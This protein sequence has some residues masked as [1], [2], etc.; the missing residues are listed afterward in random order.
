MGRLLSGCVFTV[1][2]MACSLMSSCSCE[3]FEVMGDDASTKA[4]NSIGEVKQACQ[5]DSGAPPETDG[6]IPSGSCIYFVDAD[7][8]NPSTGLSWDTAFLLV[9]DALEAAG[10]VASAGYQCEVW[11]AEGTYHVWQGQRYHTTELVPYV[12]LYGGFDGTEAER[13]QRDWNAHATILEGRN[14]QNTDDGVLHVVTG[15]DNAVIDGF[16]ITG[17]MA[18]TYDGW[19][20]PGGGVYNNSAS[21]VIRNCVINNNIAN[22]SGGGIYNVF[23]NPH[24]EN[25]VI[26]NNHS[27][28]RGGG[29]YNYVSNP[30][31]IN[32]VF[33]GNSVTSK[34]GAIANFGG[35][36]PTITNITVYNNT[37]GEAGGGLYNYYN[38]LG[39]V[40]NAIFWG[41][42]VGA[43]S[44]EIEED[45]PVDLTY[46]DIQGG[47]AGEG[48]IDID[49][50]FVDETSGD[51]RLDVGSPCIDAANGDSAPSND[52]EGR[53]R[54]DDPGT[55][56][57]G[58][59]A[60]PYTDMGAYEYV[61][62]GDPCENVSCDTPP[63][64]VCQDVDT[65]LVYEVPGTC[66]G[67]VCNYTTHTEA[68]QYGCEAG[69]C[70]PNPCEG[71]F[72]DSPPSNI[73]ENADQLRIYEPN[74]VCDNGDCS[75]AS[76][77]ADCDFGCSDGECLADP[78]MGITCNSP[79]AS[80][81]ENSSQMR[82]YE[83]TGYCELGVCSYNHQLSDCQFGCEND[84]CADD[85]C[86]GVTCEMPPA[87]YCVDGATLR[88]YQSPGACGEGDCSYAYQ[89]TVCDFGC[90]AGACNQDPCVGV[91]CN[92]P[93][94]TYCSDPDNL[95]SYDELGTCSGG[96]CTY[97]SYTDACDFGCDSGEC[98]EDPCLA[99]TCTT[100]PANSCQDADTLVAYEAEGT[101]ANGLCSYENTQVPC[102]FGCA[103]G[104]CLEDPCLAV[105][106]N[107]PPAD[108]CQDAV[109]LILHDSLGT[110]DGGVCSYTSTVQG[111]TY[112]C[113]NGTCNSP[114]CTTGDC[115]E[116]GFFRAAGFECRASGG[117]CD[118]AEVCS[119]D[120][121]ECPNDEFVSSGTECRAT[122]GDCDLAEQCTGA[123]AA[124]PTDTKST[125][126]CR[127][128]AGDC[129]IAESCDGVNND[130]PSDTKSTSECR[131]SAGDCDVAESCDGVNDDCP[132]DDLI[133]SGTECRASAGDC[134]LAE[135]CTGASAV[136]PSDA[137]STL[138][139]R[140]SAG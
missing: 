4:N 58:I 37:A 65:L 134:D 73:C 118:V 36:S 87:S 28:K 131:A 112:G 111:C 50:L 51:L 57:T 53:V 106:C 116:G 74:G 27:N 76:Q 16:I 86:Q 139:C 78:C 59:G 100:P 115:C 133:A 7:N 108:Y 1:S 132:S 40:T 99:V 126:E 89:D 68:C 12:S 71:V 80:V 9:E 135:Q 83:Q 32:C 67:G 94:A 25:C 109:N 101:C 75:Y 38:S 55:I 62:S 29:V 110:C 113:E 69:I 18:T 72:C 84:Q 6:G 8:G 81:C 123:S 105:T 5:E 2:L 70:L 95:V 98:L 41:N 22:K 14:P 77:L 85:P 97:Q 54:Y 127:V 82:V 49:P 52:I 26:S 79:P 136:C 114:Q 47:Y 15:S 44:S 21:P 61:P 120:S 46:S 128:S 42:M 102:D 92:T 11:V 34:G 13:E 63:A 121:G 122:A 66:T 43:V 10:S 119:G 56:D 17:G 91:T 129:D 3:S 30:T 20:M 60:V 23:S 124:C 125:S 24:I 103:D 33:T 130:C 104:Q 117:A 107:T 93:P 45:D 31:I 138:E 64:N 39:S 137:K 48:N 35:S 90:S 19:D 140:A 96:V 88:A